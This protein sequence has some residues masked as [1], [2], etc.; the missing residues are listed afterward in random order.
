MPLRIDRPGK[1]QAAVS[2][3]LAK[4][5]VDSQ[6]YPGVIPAALCVLNAVPADIAQRF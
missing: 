4:D 1:P 2:L 3:D 5:F 6:C